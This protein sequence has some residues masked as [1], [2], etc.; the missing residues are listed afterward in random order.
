MI[1]LG[2]FIFRCFGNSV[3]RLVAVGAQVFI[4]EYER[5]NVINKGR[6]GE[7]GIPVSAPYFQQLC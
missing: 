7:C 1:T 6:K 5:A 3:G 2:S 4:K